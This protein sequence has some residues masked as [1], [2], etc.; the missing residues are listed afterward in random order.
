M[1]SGVKPPIEF[2]RHI[3]IASGWK[4]QHGESAEPPFFA[5]ERFADF[6]DGVAIF[7]R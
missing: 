4:R 3:H 6:F 5:A 1:P 7:S 2:V